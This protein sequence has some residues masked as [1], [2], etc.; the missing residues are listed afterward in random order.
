[1]WQFV[2][3]RASPWSEQ[4]NFS[5]VVGKWFDSVRDER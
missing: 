4:M 1:M 3:S 5:V 2:R